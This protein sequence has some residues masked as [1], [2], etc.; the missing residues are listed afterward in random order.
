MLLSNHRQLRTCLLNPL[1][2]AAFRSRVRRFRLFGQRLSARTTPLPRTPAP[3]FSV[4]LV[5]PSGLLGRFFGSFSPCAPH[6]PSPPPREEKERARNGG[7]LCVSPP[8][9]KD[10]GHTKEFDLLQFIFLGFSIHLR[11]VPQGAQAVVSWPWTNEDGLATGEAR[12]DAFLC[13]CISP[14]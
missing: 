3:F 2:K 1:R 7:S 12:R 4:C 11:S 6:T 10:S 8:V 5:F 9:C 14:C 13:T